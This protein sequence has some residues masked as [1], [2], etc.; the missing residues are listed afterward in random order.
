ME[1]MGKNIKIVRKEDNNLIK[2]SL[3]D[4]REFL[5]NY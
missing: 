4:S 5:F 2:N 1:I 3:E